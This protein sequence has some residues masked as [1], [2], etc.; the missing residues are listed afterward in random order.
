[1]PTEVTIMIVLPPFLIANKNPRAVAALLARRKGKLTER[2][3]AV[4]AQALCRR[5]G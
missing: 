1:L 2:Q 4:I 3:G 5:G